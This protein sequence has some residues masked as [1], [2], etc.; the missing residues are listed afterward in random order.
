MSFLTALEADISTVETEVVNG[1]KTVIKYID[2]VFVMDVEP[3]IV[4]ALKLL[5]RNGGAMLLAVATNVLP[6][7]VAG[8]WAQAVTNLIADAKTAGAQMIAEEE[9]LAA[10][11]ALQIVQAAQGAIV[12][13]ADPANPP[14]VS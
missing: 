11:T 3:A 13:A 12:K 6:S 7:L 1:A 2:N 10:S 4:S 14:V 8:Q 9:Q 5:E